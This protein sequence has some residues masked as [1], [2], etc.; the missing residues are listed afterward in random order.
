MRKYF[1]FACIGLGLIA[2]YIFL[3]GCKVVFHK[4]KV[5]IKQGEDIVHSTP[6]C[7]YLGISETD[8][9]YM[10]DFNKN[11]GSK[12]YSKNKALN[13]VSFN[14]CNY[15]FSAYEVNTRNEHFIEGY[16]DKYQEKVIEAKRKREERE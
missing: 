10:R 14:L 4:E 12:E 3:Q 2:F 16:K 5:Y 8:M 11:A 13:D 1:G 15:C 9:E 7:P 6:Y